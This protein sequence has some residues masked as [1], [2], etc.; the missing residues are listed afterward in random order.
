MCGISENADESHITNRR[1]RKL[2]LLA[3]PEVLLLEFSTS[4]NR[5]C[6][7]CTRAN[8]HLIKKE[9]ASKDQEFTPAY[10]LDLVKMGKCD[11]AKLVILDLPPNICAFHKDASTGMTML[12]YAARMG[13]WHFAR[14]LLCRRRLQ[15][16]REGRP[17]VEKIS[18]LTIDETYEAQK[19]R[20]EEHKAKRLEE[21]RQLLSVLNR[22]GQDP[23]E[24]ACCNR[25]RESIARL[26]LENG[27]DPHRV[28]EDSTLLM[29]CCASG[30]VKIVTMLVED[31]GVNIDA[32]SQRLGQTALMKAALW[33]EVD[34]VKQL[35]IMNAEPGLVD[36]HGMSAS[37]LAAKRAFMNP[38]YGEVC[39]ALHAASTAKASLPPL[40]RDKGEDRIRSVK[41]LLKARRQLFRSTMTK[42]IC[43]EESM[44]Q[45]GLKIHDSGHPKFGYLARKRKK[46]AQNWS[47][48]FDKESQCHYWYNSRT[49]ETTFDKPWCCESP[50]DN[51]ATG[52]GSA[53]LDKGM[54]G[55][56]GSQDSDDESDGSEE[57]GK[58]HNI[59]G[60]SENKMKILFKKEYARQAERTKLAAQQAFEE[61][62]T[63]FY[64]RIADRN[65]RANGVPQDYRR[66]RMR[67]STLEVGS[68]DESNFVVRPYNW[69]VDYNNSDDTVYT[70]PMRVF[71][72]RND[73]ECCHGV[74]SRE[75]ETGGKSDPEKCG[76][77]LEPEVNGERDGEILLWPGP[78]KRSGLGGFVGNAGRR[79]EGMDEEREKLTFTEEQQSNNETLARVGYSRRPLP[80]TAEAEAMLRR[81]VASDSFSPPSAKN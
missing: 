15:D 55:H 36:H 33:A 50:R 79:V 78:Y 27:A 51:L 4:Y 30:Q 71:D 58:E 44:G 19:A 73:D 74:I 26:F 3:K 70:R 69:E 54:Y 59:G 5:L 13:L 75:E 49:E 38:E 43:V 31:Y 60:E 1:K 22:R 42:A 62:E 66:V 72:E 24:I 7:L 57:K 47:L 2:P 53:V 17:A 35:L 28:H 8:D 23:L 81:S 63:A 39:A 52:G 11:L 10:A 29:R 64:E 68:C 45:K 6:T 80:R 76:T 37:E 14:F 40:R 12:H 25:H 56:A 67:A 20:V 65:T 77:Q 16:H 32:R 18:K 61:A 41:D 46:A 48:W 21:N 34:C 9:R